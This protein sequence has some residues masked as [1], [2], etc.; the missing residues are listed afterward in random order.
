G[1]ADLVS[2]ALEIALVLGLLGTQI[3]A[4]TRSGD[5]VL[6]PAR[7]GPIGRVDLA[8]WALVAV[9][10]TAAIALGAA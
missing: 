10:S 1:A 5:G 3:G 4:R 9:L 8:I 2:T 6:A 7:S